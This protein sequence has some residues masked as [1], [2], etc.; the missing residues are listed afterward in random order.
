MEKV[1]DIFEKK[2]QLVMKQF[3]LHGFKK[4]FPHLSKVI[5]LTADEH[6]KQQSIE[7]ARWIVLNEIKFNKNGKWERWVPFGFSTKAL[8]YYSSNELYKAFLI[9]QFQQK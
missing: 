3:N 4:Y 2:A 7:Y 9:D 6:A 1:E 5:Q 8:T